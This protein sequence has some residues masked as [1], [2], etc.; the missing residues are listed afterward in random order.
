MVQTFLLF[1]YTSR[2]TGMW[3]NRLVARGK[4]YLEFIVYANYDNGLDVYQRWSLWEENQWALFQIDGINDP[5]LWRAAT[6]MRFVR[7]RFWPME[8]LLQAMPSNVDLFAAQRY[9]VPMKA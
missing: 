9:W 2:G 8:E 4:D 7:D 5:N 6:S 1:L 3:R